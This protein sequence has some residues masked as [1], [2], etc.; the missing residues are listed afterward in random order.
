MSHIELVEA[1]GS[2]EWDMDNVIEFRFSGHDKEVFDV[3]FSVDGKRLV[4]ASR[5]KT[6]RLIDVETRENLIR[7][8]C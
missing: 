7:T 8:L 5:D 6:A 4:T 1:Y 2:G 3:N